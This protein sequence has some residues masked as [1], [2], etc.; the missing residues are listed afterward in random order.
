M[1][2]STDYKGWIIK[3]NEYNLE[4]NCYLNYEYYNSNDCDCPI[5]HDV[6]IKEAKMN[7]DYL[8]SE[9]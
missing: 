5:W 1:K 3:E 4:N 2:E 7:I 9:K 6:T 8:I